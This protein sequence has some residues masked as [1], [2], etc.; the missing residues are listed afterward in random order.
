SQQTVSTV[1][2]VFLDMALA[3]G[4][5]IVPVRFTGGL[6]IEPLEARIEFPLGYGK[7]D[8]WIGRPILPEQL[9]ALPF[10]DRKEL[11]L[12]AINGLGPSSDQPFPPNP[13]FEARVNEWASQTGTTP[14]Y[15]A[16]F[17]TL[18]ALPSPGHDVKRLIEAAKTGA[19]RIHN[20]PTDRWLSRLASWFYGDRGP[21][22]EL[23]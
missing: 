9:A 17:S 16:L 3:A 23:E 4:A 11:V 20:T 15:A 7:Q 13:G 14:A 8:Y 6:P 10:K 12:S 1:S 5:P 18:E 22:I 19:L 2:S 21:R